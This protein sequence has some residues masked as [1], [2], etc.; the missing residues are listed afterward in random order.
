[1]AWP[2]RAELVTNGSLEHLDALARSY[3]RT[4]AYYGYVYPVAQRWRETGAI[5]WI[6]VRGIAIDEIYT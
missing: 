6:P 2:D 3:T 4:P 1:M 5:C